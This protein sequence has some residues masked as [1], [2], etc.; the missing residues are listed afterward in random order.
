MNPEPENVVDS[1]VRRWH[2]LKKLLL[3]D[4][5]PL[6][7]RPWWSKKAGD[8][9]GALCAWCRTGWES[10]CSI[11]L[12]LCPLSLC[13]PNDLKNGVLLSPILSFYLFF[14]LSVILYL[15]I[16]FFSA[17]YSYLAPPFLSETMTV[18]FVS[19]SSAEAVWV[20]TTQKTDDPKR[21]WHRM[22]SA[23]NAK[24]RG[25]IMDYCIPL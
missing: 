12:S 13:S 7:G 20:S 8:S 2:K 11:A 4:A 10:L 24:W 9:W 3:N 21:R 16:P 23:R 22:S 1:Y 14:I 5:C 25:N 6:M 15:F 19:P 18:F 17:S